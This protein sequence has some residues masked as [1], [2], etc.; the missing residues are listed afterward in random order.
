M[1]WFFIGGIISVTVYIHLWQIY[2]VAE[3]RILKVTPL[4][5]AT[6]E[7]NVD[8]FFGPNSTIGGSGLLDSQ[9]VSGTH[10]YLL[11]SRIVAYLQNCFAGNFYGVP[12]LY[13]FGYHQGCKKNLTDCYFTS[14]P[15]VDQWGDPLCKVFFHLG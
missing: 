2:L 11:L 3:D 7:S 14:A 4:N 15:V 8:I 10:L 12:G 6:S 1:Y 13:R 5:I 9:L